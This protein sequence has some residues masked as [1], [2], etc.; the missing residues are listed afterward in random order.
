MDIQALYTY[1][2]PNLDRVEA[3]I[4]TSL[5][6]DI[7][8]LDGINRRLREHPG[9]MLRP[10]LALLVAG[11]C[12]GVTEDTLRFAAAAELLHNATLLHDDVVDGAVERRGVPTAAKLLGGGPAVLVGDYWL[13]NCM[14]E[15]LDASHEPE[16]V[17]RIFAR[18]L[19]HLTEGELLQMEKAGK[20]D[21]S[22]ADY[23]RIIYGKTASLFEATA[24]AA[25][26]SARA[27]E[28]QVKAMGQF[29]RLLGTAFQIKD[30]ILDYSE[31]SAALGKPVGLD[32]KEQKIT[33]P[34]LCALESVS[35]PRKPR[36]LAKRWRRR[37]TIR[38]MDGS[39]RLC[40]C[41]GRRGPR[42]GGDG[43]ISGRCH[44]LPGSCCRRVRPRRTIW[45]GPG[46]F[47]RRPK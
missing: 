20:G 10:M 2:R 22:Q 30:D 34:L 35:E 41:A 6:S 21:T 39:A 19:H 32:L 17:L 43:R 45:E 29:A 24:T 40:A 47:C 8:L 44:P 36:R 38:N 3:R 4:D 15:V 11:A 33:Q 14:Q 42:P 1:L 31:S 12:G 25:A 26:I 18:T 27:S 5:R 16:R 13:V 9:K 46:P 7:A 37:R 28:E 23:L